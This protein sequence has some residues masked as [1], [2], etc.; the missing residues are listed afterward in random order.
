MSSEFITGFLTGAAL[1]IAIGAQNAFVLRQGLR[2]EHVWQI[3]MICALA[4][5]SLIAAGI[6]GLGSLIQSIPVLFKV[7]W[8]GGAV[9]LLWYGYAAARRALQ[10]KQMLPQEDQKMS[11]RAALTTC[12][13]FTFLNPHVYLDT[14]ILLGSLAN[15]AGP[16]GRWSFGI[17]AMA[18]SFSWFMGLGYG[19]QLLAPLF[20]NNLTWRLL[21]SLVAVTM[22]SLGLRLLR[23]SS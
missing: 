11:R 19:A 16:T 12:M 2:R 10:A 3:V 14:V 20:R 22:F 17:G 23:S 6:A 8:A 21:D 5:A 7:T 18:A 4:D 13:A 9:F 15:Q 1:I